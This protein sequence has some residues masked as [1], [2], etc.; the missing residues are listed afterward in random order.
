MR[1]R[2]SWQAALPAGAVTEDALS[3]MLGIIFEEL[4]RAGKLDGLLVA[5]HG[6]AVGEVHR[7]MD[8]YWLTRLREKVGRAVPIICTLDPHANLTQKMIGR[9]RRDDRL[10]HQP[11]RRSGKSRAR[12]G[13]P[14]GPDAPRRGEADAG[15][16]LLCRWRST[17]K[18]PTHPPRRRVNLCMS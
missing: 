13:R 2:C 15:R 9:L 18:P 10:P 6:A 3:T 1:C 8:G 5:P 4:G 14:H 7:D 12:S 11:A 17:S 16:G